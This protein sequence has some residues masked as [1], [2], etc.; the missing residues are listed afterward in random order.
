M[1]EETVALQPVECPICHFQNPP[2]EKF[3]Q[4]C[5]FLLGSEVKEIEL[6]TEG[7]GVASLVSPDGKEFSLKKGENTIGRES[8]D[9]LLFF[10]KSVSRKHA[11]I[12]FEEDRWFIQDLGSTNGTF[13]NGVRLPPGQ[14]TPIYDGDEIAFADSS[15]RFVCPSCKREEVK[16]KAFILMEGKE[17]PI[18]KEEFLIGRREG[19]LIV[20]NPYV[21]GKHCKIYICEEGMFI[22]DLN[23]TNGTFLNGEQI[24]SGKRVPLVDG[25]I[26]EIGGTK[27]VFRIPHEGGGKDGEVE[28][29]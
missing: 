29:G 10:D 12:T 1:S 25:A 14:K 9:I 18:S 6:P 20:P 13:L 26:I 15:F 4:D 5:G 16:A 7:E 28:G 22:E 23:S 3:C 21:S 2:G 17:I 8:A 27:L 19:D 24:E 11:I